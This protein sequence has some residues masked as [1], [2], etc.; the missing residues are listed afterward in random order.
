[1]IEG[2]RFEILS[3]HAR[4]GL[5]RILHARDRELDRPVALKE[6]LVEGDEAQA[7]FAREVMVTARLQHPAIG[8]VYEVGRWPSGKIFYAM[9]MVSG[10][11]L[12]ALISEKRSFEDRLALLPNVIAIADAVAYAHSEGLI[13]RDLKPSNVVIG[14]FGETMVVDWGLA[15]DV[16]EVEPS[17][18]EAQ[19][20]YDV[21]AAELTLTGTVMGTPEY[22]PPEQARGKKVDERADVYAIG[23]ILYHLLAGVPPYDGPSS[24]DV[25]AKVK[26]LPP[27]PLDQKEAGIRIELAAIVNKAMA[28]QAEDRYPTAKELADDLKR[29][30][31]GQLVNAHDYS[32]SDITPE[33]SVRAL[34]SVIIYFEK[35]F[36]RKR[37]E[38]VW[39]QE[40]LGLSVDYLKA[41]SNFVSFQYGQRLIEVLLAE[42]GDPDFLRKAAMLTATPEALG[43]A[44]H[45]LKAF[46]SPATCYRKM[47]EFS[48]TLNRVGRFTIDQLTPNQA[49]ITYHSD[50]WELDR[51]FC[52]FRMSQLASMPRIWGLP[53]ALAI[54]SKCQL[55]GA[56][57]CQYHLQWHSPV[58]SWR[59]Y[60]GFSLGAA[61]AI[62]VSWFGLAPLGLVL[63]TFGIIGLLAGAWLDTR[64][65]VREKDQYIATQA[66]SLMESLTEFQQRCD[67]AYKSKL[68]QKKKGDQAL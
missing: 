5:G 21:V 20:L 52:E 16:S 63:P 57:S 8:P 23:A 65:E 58:P 7:R 28:R 9:K 61:A 34:C 51:H 66:E 3:E 22:I 48:S 67:D 19:G 38:E 17:P 31:T 35:R 30:Q 15:A 44:Y 46:G 32:I 42:S 4:G 53:A 2:S 43:F 62:S 49:I 24:D 12:A 39:R 27:T 33:L 47:V 18:A 25:L 10:R 59:K 13:H 56:E 37:L 45:Y 50:V 54:E 68:D 36:G 14:P 60:G 64:A 26:Q 40:K 6:L 55:K 11:S 29:F 1:V 41:V